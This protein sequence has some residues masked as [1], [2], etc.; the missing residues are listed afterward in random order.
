MVSKPTAVFG[1]VVQFDRGKV[2]PDGRF[3]RTGTLNKPPRV[4]SANVQK[5]QAQHKREGNQISKYLLEMLKRYP[6]MEDEQYF[7]QGAK[8]DMLFKTTYNHQGSN[9]CCGCDQSKVVHRA[10]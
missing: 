10:P 4:L 3:K 8:H 7:Y 6:A 9:S 2:H 5:L 1:G